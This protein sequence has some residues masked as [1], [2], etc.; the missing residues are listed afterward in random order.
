MC[1]R[2]RRWRLNSPC[3]LIVRTVSREYDAIG[4]LAMKITAE[5]RA[6]YELH[7]KARNRIRSDLGA[8]AAGLRR[9]HLERILPSCQESRAMRARGSCK[10]GDHVR[11]RP[12]RCSSAPH[13]SP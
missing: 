1:A 5:A 6:R 9:A 7:R 11:K 10:I 2:W 12:R 8:T 4:D 3:A 13:W